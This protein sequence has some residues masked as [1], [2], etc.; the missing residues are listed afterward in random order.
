MA[1]SRPFVLNS[2]K[3]LTAENVTTWQALIELHGERHR[4]W[5]LKFA[6]SNLHIAI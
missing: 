5:N 2:F 1:K 6:P 3:E 4:I